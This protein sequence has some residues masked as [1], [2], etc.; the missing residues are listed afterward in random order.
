MFE[1]LI[2][3]STNLLILKILKL[4]PHQ[5]K[6]TKP[7]ERRKIAYLESW[8]SIIGNFFLAITKIILGFVLNSISLIAD[9]V[10]T[11]SDV[12]TS[13]VVLL[14][15]KFS[16]VPPDEKHPYGH[17][18]IE[19][20]ASL[21]IALM[22]I[23]VGFEFGKSS[24]ERFVANEKVVGSTLAALFMIISA[25]IKEWM[26]RFSIELGNRISAQALIADAWHHRT[27]A[28]ASVMV[29]IAIIS[30]KYGYYR[31]DAVFGFLVSL[32][33]VYTGVSMAFAACSKLI[34]EIAEEEV[35]KEVEE[36]ALS[37]PDVVD[38]HKIFVHD[39]GAYKEISLHVVMNNELS[40]HEAHDLSEKIE[41]L[42]E[43]KIH[44]RATV[45]VEPS[46]S[47]KN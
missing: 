33:I 1:R 41:K 15:F 20:L 2:K 9:G 25:I 28:I 8:V 13:V 36:T 29:A 14:G 32:L 46:L 19:F 22:L 12:L 42:I 45:H 38:V 31:V 26:S 30:S 44:C 47:D 16:A 21:L 11:A 40:F 3:N 35:V 18:R 34:G 5:Q 17:G 10:H 43:E 24:Y 37:H 4:D 7:H 39:Y 27:D 6:F 23:F